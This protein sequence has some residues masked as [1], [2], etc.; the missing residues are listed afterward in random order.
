MPEEVNGSDSFEGFDLDNHELLLVG[1]VFARV[2]DLADSIIAMGGIRVNVC[3]RVQDVVDE[4]IRTCPT[5]ILIDLRGTGLDG[6]GI[7]EALKRSPE[8]GAVPIMLLGDRASEPIRETAFGRGLTDFLT[9]AATVSEIVARVRIHSNSYLNIIRRNRT[10]TAYES[11]QVELRAAN[12]SLEEARR[13]LAERA[14]NP[15]DLQWQ[16]RVSGLMQIGIELNQ[17]QDFHTLMDRILSEARHLL[18]SEAGTIFLREGDSLRFSFFH[19]EALAQRTATGETPHV[20]SFRVPITDRSLAGWVCLTGQPLHIPDCYRIPQQAPYRFDSSFDQLLG[21]RTCS[22]VAMPLKNQSGRI[23]GVI[24]LINPRSQDGRS[25][26]GFTPEDIR[27]LEHFAS[28]ATVAIERTNLAEGSVLRMIRMAEIRDPSETAPHVERVAGYATV[29]FEEWARRRGLEGAAFE[30]QRDRLRTA[31]KLHDVGKVG[32]PDSILKKPGRLTPEEFEEVKKHTA[33]GSE[34]FT[35]D[36]SDFDEAAREV[37]LLHHERWDGNGY[38]GFD[39]GGARRGRKGEEIP[40]FARLV[41]LADVFDA[42][43]TARCYKEAWNEQRVL[44]LIQSESNKHFDPEL[45]EILFSQLDSIRRVRDMHPEH[46]AR[47]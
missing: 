46:S 26:I 32:V 1:S 45:V 17:I 29:L 21:Y 22:M 47:T 9:E 41:G 2:R 35:H 36:P 15:D 12:R 8:V 24:E 3:A 28:I 6:L 20:S 7:L 42:L 19:N 11:L 13:Q 27:L 16:L 25:V 18:R 30:R 23:L 39:D 43:S 31:A 37:A 5:S 33:I 38:P 14:R 4:A 44:E 10:A 40:L 34:L